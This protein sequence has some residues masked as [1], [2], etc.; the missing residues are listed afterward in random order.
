MTQPTSDGI[1]F[2]ETVSLAHRLAFL[3]MSSDDRKRLQNIA[4]LLR[5]S[6]EQFV[7]SFYKHLF[8][9]AETARFLQDPTL[10]ERLK[11]MQ[12]AHLESMLEDELDDAYVERRRRVGDVHASIGVSPQMFLGAY[13][14]YLQY[15]LRQLASNR[16]VSLPDFVEEVL[17][18]LKA[19]FLDVEL[20]LDAYFAHATLNLRQA[21]DMLF[22]ANTELRQFA[23]LASHDLKTPLATVANLCDE[24]LDEFGQQMPAE[25]CRL[26][27]MAKQRT[28]RMS[29]M[30][31]E[32][33]ELSVPVDDL[34]ANG[35]VDT[36]Q[37]IAEAIERLSSEID[38]H[39]V[40]MSLASNLPSA[41]GNRVRLREAIFNILSNAI[42]FMDKQPAT[43]DISAEIDNE[44][45][46]LAIADNGP[47]IPSEDLERIF[48]AFRRLK[49]HQDRPGTGLGLYFAR[50]LIEQDGG[51]VWAESQ[52]GKG[53]VFYITLKR[54]G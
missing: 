43:V 17:S 41:W 12:Q 19:T 34:N 23:Q 39:K 49:T 16:D 38:R 31:D 47:G 24:T 50:H 2:P 51:R 5:A 25:A 45:C 14:Q 54:H 11:R 37:V 20:T 1:D 21:L 42:K 46:K 26:V 32:L 35:A 33:L 52:L 6:S 30:I 53:S 27:E 44:T 9:F 3:Q 18:L 40:T 22:R 13:N 15:G 48:S 28:Y 10:V 8:A 36:R 4:P 7:D 29:T